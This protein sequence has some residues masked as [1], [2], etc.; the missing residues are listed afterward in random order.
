[1]PDGEWVELYN[2][3]NWSIDINGWYLYDAIDSHDLPITATNV[4]GGSTIIPAKGYLAVYRNTDPLFSLNND[5][6]NVRLYDGEIG[7]GNLIN[8]HS[9]TGTVEAKSWSGMPNGAGCPVCMPRSTAWVAV[10][11]S[12]QSLFQFQG[13]PLRLG[14]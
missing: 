4:G 1:M 6:D 9:Y 10:L 2:K 14:R 7:V 12:F 5:T 13:V 11:T 3:G 8:S